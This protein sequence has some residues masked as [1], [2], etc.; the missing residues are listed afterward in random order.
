MRIISLIADR[1]TCWSLTSTVISIQPIPVPTRIIFPIFLSNIRLSISFLVSISCFEAKSS[2]G[3]RITTRSVFSSCIVPR[4]DVLA[5]LPCWT[6]SEQLITVNKAIKYKIK[7]SLIFMAWI[8]VYQVSGVRVQGSG[9]G[10][11]TQPYSLSSLGEDR[12][13]TL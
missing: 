11:E 3:Q 7:T 1:A 4:S 8:R 5:I 2:P 10:L 13:K 9:I 12:L 6:S